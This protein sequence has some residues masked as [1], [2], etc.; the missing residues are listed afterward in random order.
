MPPKAKV[1]EAMSAVADGRVRLTGPTEAR[2]T[3]SG[4]ERTYTVRWSPDLRRITS[5]DNASRWQGY[6]GY[7]IV[8]VLMTLERIAADAAVTRLL[9]GVPWKH[10]ND[11]FQ[12]DYDR[13]VD[14][15]LREI[16]AKG[17]DAT[18]VA[19]QAE[20]I[21]SQLA[22]LGLGRGPLT[23]KRTTSGLDPS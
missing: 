19:N 18:A 14:L 12:R 21:Y 7:P 11:E 22:G 6:T 1:Y 4:G 5:D 20:S 8:A 15:V 9:A 17:G 13:A 2:V 23:E 3:S 10:L 16:A